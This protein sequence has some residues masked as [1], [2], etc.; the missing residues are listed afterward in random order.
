MTQSVQSLITGMGQLI[1]LEKL[2]NRED[3]GSTSHGFAVR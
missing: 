2:H 3:W 1:M